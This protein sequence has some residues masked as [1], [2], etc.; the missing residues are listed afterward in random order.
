MSTIQDLAREFGMQEYE[1]RAFADD[2]L[3]RYET[4]TEEIDPEIEQT[5]RE[6][7]AQSRAITES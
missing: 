2:L 6:A 7:M 3:D 5:I 1:L 4:P